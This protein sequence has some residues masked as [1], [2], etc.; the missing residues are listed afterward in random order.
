[1]ICKLLLYLKTIRNSV[2]PILRS[3]GVIGKVCCE[4][5]RVMGKHIWRQDTILRYE[6]EF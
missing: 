2:A 3:Y 5:K 4:Y 1:M 6:K